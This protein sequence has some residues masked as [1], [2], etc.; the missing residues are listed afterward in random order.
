MGGFLLSGLMHFVSKI[1]YS[2]GSFKF[3]ENYTVK[4]RK[5]YVFLTENLA[6]LTDHLGN[7]SAHG[8]QR[9]QE[10]THL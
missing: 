9:S 10:S 8:K 6:F 5:F 7:N 2:I 4:Q 1:N 3:I